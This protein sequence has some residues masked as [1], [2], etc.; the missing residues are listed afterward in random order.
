MPGNQQ[1]FSAAVNAADRYRWDS[2]WGAALHEY[3]KALTEFPEDA[4]ARSGLGFCYMQMKQWQKALDEYTFALERDPSNVI[5]L[6]KTAELYGILNRRQDAYHAYLHL[7]DLYSQAGQGARAEAAWQKAI[8]LSPGRPEPHERLAGYYFEKKDIAAMIQQRLA[9][10]QGF[11]QQNDLNAA[12]V[13]C[14]EVLRADGSNVQASQLLTYIMNGPEPQGVSPGKPTP[15]SS[16]VMPAPSDTHA[17]ARNAQANMSDNFLNDTVSAGNISGGNTGIMGNMGSA[18]NF[19]GMSPDSSQVLNGPGGTPRNRITANQV[20]GVLKQ[21]QI[22]Q[23]Q[24]RFNDAID[25]CEQILESG[26]DRPDARYFLGWLYQEQQRWDD[27]INQFQMLLNDA[28][29]ALSCYYA[30][31]QC[32]RARGD[33]RTATV[34]FDEAVDRVN[35]DALTVEESDQL[36]QLCQEAAEAHRLLGE[37]EQALTVYNA[38]LGFLRSRGWNDKVAQVE[39]MLQQA[40][41][42]PPQSRPLT[43]PPAAPQQQPQMPPQ[44]QAGPTPQTISEASTMMFNTSNI[45]PG[46]NTPPAQQ[47][48]MQQPAQQPPMPNA[49]MQQS[50]GGELPDWLTGIISENDAP[51]VPSQPLPPP[52]QAPQQQMQQQQQMPPQQMQQQQQM[53]PQQSSSSWLTDG[54]K[55]N[56]T[57]VLPPETMSSA[58]RLAQLQQPQQAPSQPLPQQ[59]QPQQ[60]PSQPLPQQQQPTMPPVMPEAPTQIPQ[61]MQPQAPMPTAADQLA[62]MQQAVP[63]PAPQAAAPALPSAQQMLQALGTPPPSISAPVP[64]DQMSLMLPGSNSSAEHQAVAPERKQSTEELL[65]QMAGNQNMQ[66]ADAVIASTATLPESVRPQVVRAM[67]DIQN[68]INHGLL[69][70]ATEACL[71]VIDMAPQYLD[72]HQVLCEIYVRQGMVE[73]A[74]TKYGILV[75]TYVVNGRIEDAIATYRRILQLDPNNL[76]YRMRLINMLSSQGNK[77]DLLRE[78]TLAAESYLRLG[79]MDRALTELEQALQESPTSVSTRL[80]YALALQKLGRSQQAVAE[81]QRV[82]QVD[83]RNITALV[84]WHVAQI[85]HIGAA[86][87]NTLEVLNRIRWQLRGEGQKQADAVIREYTQAADIYPN[88]A[89]VHYA[90]GQLYQQ[91][92]LFDQALDSYTLASR[93]SAVEVLARVG[94]A[95]CYLRQGKPEAAIQQLDQAL[96]AVKRSSTAMDPAT[97]A[98]RPREEGEEHKAPEVELSLLLAKTYG[99]TGR[100]DQMD[101]IM[102]QVKQSRA[103][104][105]EVASTLEEISMRR[106]D[107]SMAVQEYMDLVRH[108][109]QSRQIDNA[110]KVLNEMVR[111]VPQEPRAHEELADIYIN[112]GLLDEG[113]AELRLLVDVYLRRNNT[114]EA[115]ATLQ[116]I[117]NIY[118]EMGNSDE[119]L[120]SLCRAAELNPHAMDLLREVVGFCFRVGRPHEAAK[121]QELIAR[122]YF[123]T[124][125]VKEAVAALQQLIT[126]DRNNYEAYDMLGQTYQTVGEY[127]QASRVYRNLAKINPGSSVAR[128]RLATLQELRMR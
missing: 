75:D 117:G 98:A 4:T 13:Q 118:D 123:E 47:Q 106:P 69:T 115:A 56:E 119:A 95:H 62:A 114:E 18:G 83:P 42:A 19:G 26:F 82:L 89:D 76:T 59:Q 127:E 7:A 67:Q 77:E 73:Q 20:T 97:W 80:N 112:R 23:D 40:Q 124:Q 51:Q 99:R 64:P 128:E 34:H 48:P 90:L 43:P 24:G 16:E 49:P 61:P 29:Y 12:R 71:R 15:T 110:L 103:G 10:A 96:Q 104:Q 107:P 45:T 21:A 52:P 78:R 87:S 6:S 58:E 120:A 3:Q 46:M 22:F 5:A 102:R 57:R 68:Y 60:A 33:L 38:L 39:F 50:M 27:A 70:P 31:G 121:Y 36:V 65:S 14:E 32:Y 74:I 72:V 81:Y 44:Q 54:A 88:N 66:A 53:P 41:S 37:Q 126:I 105:D 100:V 109:R 79:Y 86:R 85:T 9:A 2:Q 84:R 92:G 113:I 93:D 8:Q 94:S 125:Q 30:L 116:R 28:D 1:A 17:Q 108:Y 101:A 111:A 35:L 11:M 63:A 91:C 55:P 122:H 25:L